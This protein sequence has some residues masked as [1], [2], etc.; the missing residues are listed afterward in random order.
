MKSLSHVRLF[1]TPW[2][3]AY[4]APP[5]MEFSRQEYWSGLPLHA[6][7]LSLFSHVR[8]FE[9]L[10]TTSSQFL[11]P[12]DSAGKNTEVDCCAFVQGVFLAQVVVFFLP[13]EPPGKSKDFGIITNNWG[14]KKYDTRYVALL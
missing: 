2:A 10:W 6:C 14:L 5:F 7:M 1:T 11:C 13:P 3:E 9:I 12:W 8:L 4:Q